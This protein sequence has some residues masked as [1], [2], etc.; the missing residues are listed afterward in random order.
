VL[1]GW[2]KFDLDPLGGSHIVHGSIDYGFHWLTVFYDTG[3]IWDTPQERSP[4][5]SVGTGF[6]KDG[7]QLAVAFPIRSARIEPIVYAGLNF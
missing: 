6:K 1:R 3:V 7:F 4:K 2:N 5:Q